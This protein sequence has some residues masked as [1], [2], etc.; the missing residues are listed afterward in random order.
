MT[1]NVKAGRKHAPLARVSNNAVV[2]RLVASRK[3][4][5]PSFNSN[6]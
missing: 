5:N 1:K 3:T 6:L 4:D 2:Q